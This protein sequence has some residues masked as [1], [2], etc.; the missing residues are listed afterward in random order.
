[1]KLP[2]KSFDAGGS[3]DSKSESEHLPATLSYLREE[4][5]AFAASLRTRDASQFIGGRIALRHAMG[6]ELS[7][8]V[9][10]VLRG[11]RG[12]PILA[13]CGGSISHKD[14]VAVALVRQAVDLPSAPQEHCSFGECVGIDVENLGRRRRI[15]LLSKKVL[16]TREGQRLGAL[17]GSG[18]TRSEEVLLS[19]SFKEAIYKAIDPFLQRRVGFKEVEVI[20]ASDGTCFARICHSE[21]NLEI[22]LDGQWKRVG[23]YN[24]TSILS[25][26][27]I[28]DWKA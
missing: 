12:A 7:R 17:S 2:R 28:G 25:Q 5:L 22:A 4:E 9:A 13:L 19:F 20:P 10:P 27:K 18:L 3:F 15:D 26:R 8:R 1:V 11:P 21:P 24:V 16:T 6:A 14:E 23:E